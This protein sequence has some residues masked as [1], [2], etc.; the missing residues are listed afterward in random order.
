MCGRD[1][2][3][4]Q[5]CALGL[6]QSLV[7]H[8]HVTILQ[9]VVS[10]RYLNTLC[11]SLLKS[12]QVDKCFTVMKIDFMYTRRVLPGLARDKLCAKSLRY[13]LFTQFRT[14]FSLVTLVSIKILYHNK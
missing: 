2:L 10:F 8:A 5:V 12:L 14:R 6:G 4:Q 1:S 13:Y 7:L 9:L 11:I 3:N